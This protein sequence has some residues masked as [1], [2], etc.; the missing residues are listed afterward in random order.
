MSNATCSIDGCER[1]RRASNGYCDM[2]W[3]RWKRSGD[4]L[5]LQ[6]GQRGQGWV[7]KRGYRMVTRRG[8]PQAAPDGRVFEHRAILFDAIGPGTHLCHWCET[9]VSWDLAAP[10]DD[11]ALVVDHL[12]FDKLNNDRANLVPS[13]HP[14]NAVQRTNNNGRQSRRLRP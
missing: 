4:P 2:H 6:R 10:Y 7:T 9:T 8:H 11:G 13:C 12:D 5:A 14:C 3:K 1:A